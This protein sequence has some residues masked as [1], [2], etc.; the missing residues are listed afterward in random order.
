MIY[1]A[2]GFTG[3]L[4]VE[5][6]LRRGHRP[7]L[8]GRDKMRLDRVAERYGLHARAFPLENGDAMR[9][10]LSGMACVLHAAGPFATT[11][12][13]LIEA[14]LDTSTN[15]ADLSGEH[16]H[17]CTVEALDA[18]AKH[19]G[20]ALLTGAGFGVTF[21]DC[22]AR[23]TMNLLPDA[24]H[25]RLSVAAENAQT[26]PALRRTV[27]EVLAQGG[28]AIEG[29]EQKRR[30]LA[31]QR[32]T[33]GNGNSALSFAAAPLG[34]LAALRRSTGV[35]NI[36]V[37]RPMPMSAAL[38][39][40][41]LSTPIQSATQSALQLR[42]IHRLLSRENSSRD[43]PV[44]KGSS[45]RRSSLW[46]EARN[47]S[48]TSIT[49]RLDTG[50]GYAATAVAALANIEALLN[51]RLVGAMTPGLAFGARHLAA[52]PDVTITDAVGKASQPGEPQR[53]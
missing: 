32:W 35:T 10:H 38:I 39:L 8:A 20:I 16:H 23:R 33:I 51:H 50:E 49:S 37:G 3:Q 5:E 30:P 12:A 22:L 17:L 41:T 26:T 42:E 18:E 13:P 11:G 45:G 29:G 31:H 14:C 43:R 1:G 46:L 34:E 52:I 7:L 15:Y 21:G 47:A 9:A 27:M 36:V 44:S 24:T 40:R 28:Y 6:A 48:G 2:Y 25:L 53:T 19:A 4:V